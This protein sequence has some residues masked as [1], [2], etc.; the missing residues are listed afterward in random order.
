MCVPGS[1]YLEVSQQDGVFEAS[2]HG[3]SSPQQNED[4]EQDP[5]LEKTKVS[6]NCS[7]IEY[8]TETEQ[9]YVCTLKN[10]E[11]TR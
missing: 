8:T 9:T 7:Y 4:K 3:I 6:K 2:Q 11:N 1:W 5:I 10:V